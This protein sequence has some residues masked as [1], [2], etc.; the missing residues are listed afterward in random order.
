MKTLAGCNVKVKI[1]E[2]GNALSYVMVGQGMAEQV[3]TSRLGLADLLDVLLSPAGLR[4]DGDK[5]VEQD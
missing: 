4:A 1:V 2:C 3:G 5:I